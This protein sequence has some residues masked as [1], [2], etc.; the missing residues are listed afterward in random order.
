[1]SLFSK[2]TKTSSK[3]SS[4]SAASSGNYKSPDGM[5]E[6]QNN[7][8]VPNI[9]MTGQ[10]PNAIYVGGNAVASKN[11][12]YK[13]PVV[14]TTTPKPVVKPTVAIKTPAKAGTSSTSSTSSAYSNPMTMPGATSSAS[15]EPTIGQGLFNISGEADP[16]Q[17]QLDY[18]KSERDR[19]LNPDE[20]FQEKLRMYQGQMDSIR[21]IY[22]AKLAETRQQGIGRFG[23]ARAA[24]ARGGLLG[25]D[26]AGAQNDT[27]QNFNNQEEDLVRAEEASRIAEIMG[28][29]R[30]EASAEIASRREAQRQGAESYT[31]WLAK[32]Q[33]R[34]QTGLSNLAKAIV[35]SGI[36]DI[37]KLGDD[38]IKEIASKYGTSTDAVRAA[39]AEQIPATSSKDRYVTLSDG[40]S[41]YD[42]ETGQ[43]VAENSKNFA[44]KAGTGGGSSGTSALNISGA[45]QAYVDRI[46]SGSMTEEE[47]MK[48]LPGVANSETRNE[49]VMAISA[50]RGT[51]TGTQQRQIDDQLALIE[52]LLQNK[53][54]KQ[55]AVGAS[56]AKLVPLGKK[57]GL[58]PKRVG[59]ET[60]AQ[61]LAGI[62]TL[63]KLG[64]LKGPLSDSDREFI[65]NVSTG[66]SLGMTEKEFDKKLN[67]IKGKLI[68]KSGATTTQAPATSGQ[69]SVTAPNGKTYYFT[70]QTDANVFKA[71]AG[72]Q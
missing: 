45:A 63:D 46:N 11:P 49:I 48:A 31:N 26:F 71:K 54:G 29:A 34:K 40:A 72:I 7:A 32:S 41:I 6:S 15:G 4:P 8:L 56:P 39:V 42:T 36:T 35:A 21:D 9:S 59:Y 20:I 5:I 18:Y 14:A 38:N 70:N 66:Y 65:Q 33:E 62:L 23:S 64:V 43:I 28:M 68:A 50:Q 37:T 16:Y 12:N 51:L 19:A 61:Q 10:N 53:N 30:S 58:Q 44:P 3:I 57:A 27:V 24:Q 2:K 60:K 17:E 25:S 55:A 22:A 67:S 1:M 13:P 69:I 52:D 47:A